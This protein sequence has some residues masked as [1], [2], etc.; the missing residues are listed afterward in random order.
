MSNPSTFK[1]PQ[2]LAHETDKRVIQHFRK[3]EK[4]E[5]KIATFRNHLHFTLHC[6]HHD[7]TPP[8]LKLKC[9]SKSREATQIIERAQK[10]LINERINNIKR[11]LKT[12][13]SQKSEADEFL[14]TH[15]TEN[16]TEIHE[17]MTHAHNETFDNIRTRQQRKFGRLLA[18][19]NKNK[20]LRNS[21][22]VEVEQEEAERIKSKWIV[23]LSNRTLTSEEET[24][25]K[26][27]MNFAVTPNKIPVDEFVIGIESACRVI[28]PH[29][30]E[31]ETLRSNC[32]RI[33]KNAPPPK[34][35]LKKEER[36]ALSSLARDKTITIVP[37]DKGRATVVMNT[38][39]YKSKANTL[40]SDTT[41]YQKLEKDPTP[42]FSQTL[43]TQLKDL[44]KEG[45]LEEHQYRR[46]YPTSATVPRFYGLPKVHKRDTPLRPIVASRGSITYELAKLLA[47]ILSPLVGKNGYALKNSAAMVEELSLLTLSETDVLVSFDVT[48]LFTKVPVDKSLDIV[49]DR[50]EKDDSL[51]NRTKLS[52]VQVRD[53]LRTCLKTTYFQ[54]DGIL[55]TQ[56]E[57]AAMGSPVSPIVANLFME[58]FEEVALQSF[59]FEI[60]VW[61]RYG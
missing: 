59:R 24:V 10:A 34:P 27:G 47:M 61:K 54:Y 28:G 41:T 17:W 32:V 21:P 57:G 60:T 40:L 8:S 7:V 9:A 13:G 5:K 58:W 16:Y 20:L 6:K 42:K 15:S 26:K 39:D 43:I 31:A 53:L 22:I 49:F 11:K 36:E 52:P 48:A 44:K 37:A 19:Q 46:L 2:R 35:N 4:T 38:E 25:L 51:I 18:Q 12:F 50:L 55:Y 3:W 23:N 33:L 45:V 30:K 1:L 56:V 29:T 14:F